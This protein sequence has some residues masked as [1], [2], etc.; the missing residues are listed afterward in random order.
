[1][2]EK[3]EPGWFFVSPRGEE[4]KRRITATGFPAPRARVVIGGRWLVEK[5]LG[6]GGQGVTFVVRDQTAAT[7]DL[8]V[9]KRLHRAGDTQARARFETEV[10]A[11]AALDHPNILPVV[12]YNITDAEPWF[13]SEY[14]EGGG[15]DKVELHQLTLDMKCGIFLDVCS[16]LAAAHEKRITHRDIKPENVLLK[17]SLGP[18]VLGDFGLCW[19]GKTDDDRLTRAHE[20]IGSSF[21]RAPELFDGPLEAV[22]P[23]SDVYCLGKLLYWLMVGEGGRAGRLHREEYDRDDKNLMQLHNDGKFDH[24]NGLLQR[25]I[26]QDPSGRFADAGEV[27]RA[28]VK[29]LDLFLSGY[30]PLNRAP[31]RCQYCGRGSYGERT[32]GSGT[33]VE[34]QLMHGWHIF[35]CKIC[36]HTLFF[37]RNGRNESW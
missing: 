27:H 25:M 11:L 5:E 23:R 10:K 29:A 35:E 20:D 3:G 32:P 16:A 36:G 33:S 2:V 26:V 12:D 30:Q 21:C 9:L 34:L 22:G 8:Y 18:A 17:S 13:V 7:D 6:S 1:L 4:E 14:C 31:E 24:V 28:A 15:L 19:L 37:R